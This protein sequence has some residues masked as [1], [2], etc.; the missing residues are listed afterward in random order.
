[1]MDS[2]RKPSDI[3][4][5]VRIGFPVE[6]LYR[7]GNRSLGRRGRDLW[8]ED[9][10]IGHGRSGL[11]HGLALT[12]VASVDVTERVFGGCDGSTLVALGAIGARALPGSTPRQLTDITVRT[13]DG[14]QAVWVV[15]RRGAEW[16]REQLAPVLQRALIPFYDELPPDDR[17]W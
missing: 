10:K 2:T 4:T 17:T 12:E 13:R 8:V 11:R 5:R 16:V 7:G 1:M 15:E 6:C 9:G 3:T 14:Q